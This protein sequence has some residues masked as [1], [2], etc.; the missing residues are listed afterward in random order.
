MNCSTVEY[1]QSIVK[2][3]PETL[4]IAFDSGDARLGGKQL[5]DFG[6]FEVI[7]LS[8]QG[9]S[10]ALNTIDRALER[11]FFQYQSEQ[12]IE[13]LKQHQ[14]LS[15]SASQGLVNKEDA[16]KEWGLKLNK[17]RKKLNEL[18][19]LLEKT[20]SSEQRYIKSYLE[21]K[22]EKEDLQERLMRRQDSNIVADTHYSDLLNTLE[23]CGSVEEAIEACMFQISNWAESAALLFFKYIP[24]HPYLVLAQSKGIDS[25][26]YR[27]V[28]VSMTGLAFSELGHF[29]EHGRFLSQLDSVMKGAFKA[30]KYT[31]SEVKSEQG[32][33][34]IVVLLKSLESRAQ[35]RFFEDCISV[36]NLTSQK[37]RLGS[38]VSRLGTFDSLTQLQT[39]AKFE[40]VLKAEIARARRISLPLSLIYFRLDKEDI[41]R[42]N[43]SKPDIDNIVA[44]IGTILK[45]T[46]RV[47]DQLFKFEK[48][49]F[50]AVLPHTNKKGAAIKAEL[51]RRIIEK[52][53]I[54]VGESGKN[55]SK[56]SVS[57]G[58]SEYPNL[59]KDYEGLVNSADEA[60]FEVI[61]AGGNKVC[62]A[63]PLDDFSSQTTVR[64]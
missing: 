3:S 27:G 48:A 47:N 55:F 26:K 8:V 17:E 42:R 64:I 37:I 58:V 46:S 45:K 6:F 43:L 32:I 1:V 7:H 5:L 35:K 31:F 12:A 29:S 21:I 50:V 57:A 56:F 10:E 23:L 15:K 51:T 16:E 61:E 63:T 39:R 11:I 19:L 22:A 20:Q 49:E 52:S 9:A 30:E 28:G 13:E 33:L 18:E 41:L 38:K 14:N 24:G 44:T 53:F 2:G 54:K 36:L 59:C 60:L 34:G 40:E 62:L 25:D 4:N